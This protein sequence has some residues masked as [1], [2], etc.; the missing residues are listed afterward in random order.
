M[1]S[2][3][4]DLEITQAKVSIYEHAAILSAGSLSSYDDTY[5]GITFDN[6]RRHALSSH[7]VNG[8]G[9]QDL[10]RDW[11]MMSSPLSDAPLGFNYKDQNGVDHN[12][13]VPGHD[14]FNSIS[15]DP[16]GFFNNPWESN[17][18]LPMTNVL[19]ELANAIG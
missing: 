1:N 2:V 9:M 15:N 7:G 10:P 18:E 6:S 4:T 13:A 19:L 17:L 11:H 5:V 3:G 8:L 12:K 16:I 14:N